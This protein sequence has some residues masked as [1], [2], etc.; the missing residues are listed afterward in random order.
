MKKT[1]L[2][3]LSLLLVVVAN[4]QSFQCPSFKRNNGNN[5]CPGEQ[6]KNGSIPVAVNSSLSSSDYSIPTSNKEGNFTLEFDQQYSN[7]PL[8]GDVSVD[9]SKVDVEFGP[10]SNWDAK[11]N[12]YNLDYCFYKNNLAP[13]NKIM[14]MVI[15]K[16][17]SSSNY[18][19]CIY[20]DQK[21]VSGP[22]INTHPSGII[23]IC[24]GENHTFSTS[25]AG[26]RSNTTLSYQ[27]KKNGT[28]IFGATSSSLALSSLTSSNDGDYTVVVTE[29]D[30]HGNA[31]KVESDVAKLQLDK[32]APTAKA[33]NYT[34][35]LD[36]TGNAS[37]KED[38]I[39]NGSKDNCSIKDRSLDKTKFTCEDRGKDHTVTLTIED[40]QFGNRR[41]KEHRIAT[42]A[43]NRAGAES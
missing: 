10:P 21:L 13:A 16:Q 41:S 8:I 4:A 24:K 18:G 28:S 19:T 27:W 20:D 40:A 15:R 42:R 22:K 3:H 26:S 33:K 29:T 37:I 39:D 2:L 31:L 30:V 11:S 14:V 5:S 32:I 25:A 43:Y 9:G 12:S 7:I 17:G 34:V 36:E 38:D 6:V 1:I 23:N 35:E